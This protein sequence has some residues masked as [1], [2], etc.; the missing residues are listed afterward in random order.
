MKKDAYLSSDGMYRYMLYRKWDDKLPDVAYIM[1]N[2]STADHDIDDPT[3]R[4]CIG[5]A[6]SWGYG[7]IYVVNLFAFRSTDP[8]KLMFA[9]DPIGD[10]NSWWIR[11]VSRFSEKVVCAWGNGPIL[12][13]L[14]GNVS[15]L[16]Q[17]EGVKHKLHYITLSKEGVPCH[18]LYLRGELLLKQMPV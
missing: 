7:G 12:K 17:L 1:L 16:K 9:D 11:N 13:K 4:R 8:K 6:K 18:P 2:P 10:E 14:L 5:F 15:P 3:I